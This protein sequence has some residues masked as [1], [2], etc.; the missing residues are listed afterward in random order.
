MDTISR[1]RP[2][3]SGNVFFYI[4]IAVALLGALS[5]AVSQS[6]RQTGKGL[7]DDR[8]QL[9]AS[10]IISYGDTVAK[11]VGQMRLR[12]IRPH[13]ISFAHPDAP[14][15]Y[16][17]YDTNP[18][19]EVFNPQGGG[20]IFRSPP[21]LSGTGAP[22]SYNY[23]GAFAIDGVGLTGCALPASPPEDCSELLIT[24]QGLNET[25]CR[26]ANDLLGIHDR[27]QALPEDSALPVAPL[28]AGNQSGTPDPFTYSDVIGEDGDSEQLR[29]HTAGC[30]KNGANY[31]YYQVLIAR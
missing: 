7:N 26:M 20:V 10:E 9:A 29:Q 11:A 27:D 30:Y 13:Q 23:V 31:I 4:F 14:A 19:A 17:A 24:V 22:L 2:S 21:V 6:S 28:F 16:G 25:V 5:F 3:E 8:A 1:K 12:G 18:R 15:A